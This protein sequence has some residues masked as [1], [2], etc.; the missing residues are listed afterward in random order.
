MYLSLKRFIVFFIVLVYL[1][2]C[3]SDG[4]NNDG[5]TS[6]NNNK[7][8]KISINAQDSLQFAP[9]NSKFNADISKKVKS[10]NKESLI[11]SSLEHINGD[12][13]LVAT[14]KL[15]FDV[16]THG[17]DVC[18]YRYEVQSES[19]KYEG[20]A[21]GI[22][23]IVSKAEP[24]IGDFLAPVSKTTN[25]SI[26]IDFNK[27]DLHI[28]S[29]YELD[30]TSIFLTGDTISGDYGLISD[31]SSNGFK[32]TSPDS[33]G[34]IRIF[35]TAIDS[36]NNIAKP[37]A[38]YIAVGQNTNTKPNAF[39][40][41]LPN[42]AIIDGSSVIDISGYVNDDDGDDLQ[43][44]YVSAILGGADIVSD[45][46]LEYTPAMSGDE[47]ITYVVSDHN[48]GYGI[49]TIRFKVNTYKSIIDAGQLL[50]FEPPFTF[51]DL[52]RFDSF[53]GTAI[54]IGTQGINGE[55]P[56]F[57]K[58]LA[59]AYCITHSAR[60]PKLAELQTMRNTVLNNK[61]VFETDYRWHSSSRFILSDGKALSLSDGS[62]GTDSTGYFSCVKPIALKNWHFLNDVYKGT[63]N[64][65]GSN[66]D[67]TYVSLISEDASG[68]NSILPISD[69]NL[70]YEVVAFRVQDNI[71]PV[72]ENTVNY[73]L[74]I[75][76]KENSIQVD[77]NNGGIGSGV[78][79]PKSIYLKL[80]IT[81][82]IA[83]GSSTEVIYGIGL[84]PVGLS[85][86]E[87]ARIQCI[88]SVKGKDSEKFTLAIPD[89]ILITLGF[90]SSSLDEFSFVGQNDIKWRGFLWGNENQNRR[91]FRNEELKP[92]CDALS[93][94]NL[95]G[96]NNWQPGADLVPQHHDQTQFV[97]TGGD[98]D[99]SKNYTK[100]M[101]TADGGSDPGTYGQGYAPVDITNK[102]YVNQRM[103]SALYKS[104]WFTNVYTWMSCWSKS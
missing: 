84:C 88:R 29:G 13:E 92:V 102:F 22:V 34:V 52:N 23:Q 12:C 25:E 78:I 41:T 68:N 104:E 63:I 73:F 50:I 80:K 51:S 90:D 11:I 69:Y 9:E 79:D 7:P 64:E 72:D 61:P 91:K 15:T 3:N 98:Y 100:F 48:G 39:Y 53:S 6:G 58:E 94:M 59:T 76:I 54:E 77:I 30:V 56:V 66:A 86:V 75:R 71:L 31:S 74:D 67:K 95:D 87:A 101:M 20:N 65:Y 36:V 24:N 17:A 62:L 8:V 40:Q 44:V 57:T 33:Q 55:Y 49:S 70:E 47:Y 45:L 60:L 89:N 19:D 32:Y 4:S 97:Q 43:L 18:R 82:K 81:D 83:P 35:Y 26:T 21:S 46:E 99:D 37:G 16:I 93:A 10:E 42:K 38:V 96:R 28:E 5:S 1:A 14:Q 27:S 2:G 85:P 103:D